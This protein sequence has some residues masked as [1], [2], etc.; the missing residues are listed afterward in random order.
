MTKALVKVNQITNPLFTTSL[1]K[2]LR[3]ML[4][5]KTS[6]RLVRLVD[7]VD[8]E[9]VVFDKTRLELCKRL[10]EKDANGAPMTTIVPGEKHII[11]GELGPDKEQFVFSPENQNRV[12]TAVVELYNTELEFD[13]LHYK[14]L[15]Q[16]VK[17]MRGQDWLPIACLFFGEDEMDV[18]PNETKE[19]A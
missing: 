4:P 3:E 13:S 8:A 2:L 6:L 9:R 12:E 11:T 5:V 7:R 1:Q 16:E 18:P 14:E 17:M 15:G 10:A 19:Q